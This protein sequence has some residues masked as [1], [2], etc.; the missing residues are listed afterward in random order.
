MNKLSLFCVSALLMFL[1]CQSNSQ[2]E[3]R[4]ELS[5]ESPLPSVGSHGSMEYS[6]TS[7]MV[8]CPFLPLS[9][10][11]EYHIMAYFKG[12]EIYESIEAFVF[13]GETEQG[14][15]PIRAT[16]TRHD[17][18]QVDYFNFDINPATEDDRQR[19]YN[20]SIHFV[21][22][23]NG[24]GGL[25]EFTDN[26]GNDFSLVYKADR[27]V[28]EQNGG[29]TDVGEHSPHGGLPLFY[30][31][32]SGIG[33][34]NCYV[35]INNQTY[36]VP[37]DEAV[38]KR[39]FFVAYMAYISKGFNSVIYSTG[40]TQLQKESFQVQENQD[41]IVLTYDTFESTFKIV[42]SSGVPE[43]KEILSRNPWV[44]PDSFTTMI[45]DPPFPNLVAMNTGETFNLGF[46]IDFDVAQGLVY[47][48]ITVH[49]LND[50]QVY[51]EM[52]PLSPSWAVDSRAMKY[53]L[54][55]QE[56]QVEIEAKMLLE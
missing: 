19:W 9:S 10:T 30:R 56:Q 48:D 38:T 21:Y 42:T 39:P 41:E 11:A 53:I 45:F 47:G 34:E 17:K 27:G 31:E 7:D 4:G 6:Q 13:N 46:Q 12:H 16:L 51:V 5:M 18:S 3:L 55:Y 33:S 24:L 20:S 35:Q 49:K 54:N 2:G 23:D 15:S 40:V 37:V 50:R 22:E 14:D 8:I 36:E 28:S 44:S 1:A 52:N 25:L 32:K 26:S 43:I 29:L